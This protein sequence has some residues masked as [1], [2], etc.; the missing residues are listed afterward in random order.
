MKLAIVQ[1][2][3]MPYI[4]YFQLLHAVD[5]AVI[6]D[7]I[8]YTKKGWF[9]RNRILLQ[10]NMHTFTVPI[11]KDSDYLNVDQRFLAENAGKEIVKTLAQIRQNYAKSPFFNDIYPVIESCFHCKE[12]NLYRFI[13]NSIDQ[14]RSLMK[15][16]TELIASSEIPIDHSLRKEEKVMSI[17]SQLK[18]DVYYNPVGGI[19]L[20]DKNE[21]KEHNIELKFLKTS[22]FNYD[23]GITEFIPKLSIIDVLMYNGVDKTHSLLELYELI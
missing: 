19:D 12:K 3:F 1:P 21:F 2:Y 22:V 16:S 20:Y 6:Y 14:L 10:G 8:E 17:C 18:A 5:K 9:N 7:N 15:I 23:Q 13:F 11:K 4:G